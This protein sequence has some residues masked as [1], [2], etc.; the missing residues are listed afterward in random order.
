MQ[1]KW[2]A[3]GGYAH[4]IFV[5][6]LKAFNEHL[7]TLQKQVG[8]VCALAEKKNWSQTGTRNAFKTQICFHLAPFFVLALSAFA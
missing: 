1:V 7:F 2:C 6:F 8:V 4:T 3:L 5:V